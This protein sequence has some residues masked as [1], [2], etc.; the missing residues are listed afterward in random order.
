MT[1]QAWVVVATCLLLAACG[2]WSQ[3][4]GGQGMMGGYGMGPGMMGGPGPG[5]MGGYG[6]GNWESHI[7][8]LT[9]EQRGKIDTA[10]KIFRQKQ[11]Q[12][13]EKMHELNFQAGKLYRDGKFDEQAVRKNFDAMAA[14]RK[15]MFE[16]SL[17]EKRNIDNILTPQQREQMQRAWDAR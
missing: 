10:E 6:A 9:E 12:V 13:M 4:Y 3:P 8:N 7:P 2:S 15:E 11:W 5:M 1:K 16:N 14:L 17:E